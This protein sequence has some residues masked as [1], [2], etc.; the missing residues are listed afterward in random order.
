MERLG[1]NL[2]ES[3]RQMDRKSLLL[4]GWKRG[5]RAKLRS[6]CMRE[7]LDIYGV[8]WRPRTRCI[9][10]IGQLVWT[11]LSVTAFATML[12]VLSLIRQPVFYRQHLQRNL[13]DSGGYSDIMPPDG[14][15]YR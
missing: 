8:W 2:L 6:R 5:W 9:G 15:A 10:C 3:S 13:L 1:A 4:A 11:K 14:T 7:I 12:V